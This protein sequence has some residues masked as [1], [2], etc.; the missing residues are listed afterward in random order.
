MKY[1]EKKE[2]ILN[3]KSIC[4]QN[5]I[6]FKKFFEHEEYKLKR[7]NGLR[8]LDEG[9]YKTLIGYICRFWNI[10][11]WFNNK[12]LKNITKEDIKKVYD[13]LEDGNI[14]N[15]KGKPFK[16]RKSYYNKVFK[17]KL[18]HMI[19]KDEL[20][21]EVM[22]YYKPNNDD[23][24]RFIEEESVKKLCNVVISPKHKT[25][26]WLSFDIGENINSLLK[27]KKQDCIR[28]IDRD[29][30]LPE[31]RI[32]LRQEILK[33][34]RKARSEITNYQETVEFLDN[35]LKDLKDNQNVFNFQYRMA[36]KFLDRSVKIT[37][38]KCIPKG[39]AVTWKDL[40][41]SMACV[42]L[43]KGWTTDEINARLGHKP[44]SREIDKYVNFKAIGKKKPQRKVYEHNLSKIQAEMEEGKDR[45]KLLMQRMEKLNN[46]IESNEKNFG[47]LNKFFDNPKIQ[48]DFKEFVAKN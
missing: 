26:L 9:T 31:Y 45:E 48:K 8:E 14:V 6:L 4:I 40:R 7:T 24:V 36:K 34:S 15:I 17:S 22:E 44:S 35:I 25:L 12:P 11:K 41:S 5:R 38:V 1:L 19:G 13:G 10:N 47:L 27:L 18:F 20:A 30:K 46:K 21:R 28:Q 37:G 32:N 33:R 43:D 39:Q 23:E 29:T 3:E 42:L 16:D 2:K